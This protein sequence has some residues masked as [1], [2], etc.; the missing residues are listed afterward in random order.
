LPHV[1]SDLKSQV[2]AYAASRASS[3]A[4]KPAFASENAAATPFD[5]IL[6]DT[7]RAAPEPRPQRAANDSSARTD[8]TERPKPADRPDRTAKSDNNDKPAAA[9]AAAKTDSAD[10]AKAADSADSTTKNSKTADPA[11]ADDLK[12]AADAAKQAGDAKPADAT[13]AVVAVAVV[14]DPAVVA[15]ANAQGDTKGEVKADTAAIGATAA[16]A[17][18]AAT[19]QPAATAANG[20]AEQADAELAKGELAKA[21]PE[22]LAALAAKAD[23]ADAKSE[24]K[25]DKKAAATDKPVAAG[26]GAGNAP[27]LLHADAADPAAAGEPHKDSSAHARAEETA[28]THRGVATDTA[29]AAAAG[30]DAGNA[31][32]PKVADLTPPTNLMT[33][34]ATAQTVQ[35]QAVAAP[36]AA[37]HAAASDAAVPIAG[38]AFEITSKA[39]AGKGQFDIRLDPPDLGKIHVRLD[40]DRDG[41]VITHMVADRTD[42]LDMLRKDTAGL[43]RALQ[44]AGLKTS[45][46]SL[47]FSLRD[48]S[49]NQQQSNGGNANTAHI[50]VE[51]EQLR[52]SDTAQRNYAR[53]NAPT[54]GLDI[55]V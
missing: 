36:T 9:D 28:N 29:A 46:N 18:A 2:S 24:A 47:Q 52:A 53:Y 25:T 4:A 42:T 13:A 8:R 31:I 21:T 32:A 16:A 5:S 10:P 27:A 7:A 20:Q 6:D 34:P 19:A 38:V 22:A 39:L 48:Q 54:G 43:E 35:A 37:A 44:D 40:V 30:N 33:A 11:T 41:N 12:A 51:D 55:R 1:A 15:A 23:K 45:D 14:I 50:V 26:K 3:Q 49:A 17:A